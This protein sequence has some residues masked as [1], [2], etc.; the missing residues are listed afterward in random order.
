MSTRQAADHFDVIV[1]GAGPAG[2]A[3][4]LTAARAG[5]KVLLIERGEYPGA[6]NVSG[7]VFY[8]S[9]MLHKVIPNWWEQAP[10]ERFVC[11]RDVILMSPTTAVSLDFRTSAKDYAQPPYNAFTVLRPKFDRWFAGQAEAAGAFL[12]TSTVVDDVIVERGRVVGVRVRREAGE[13]RGDVVIACDG[14]NSLLARRA[15]LQRELHAHELSLGVKEVLGM[16]EALI[17]ERFN[18]SGNE[19]MAL[20]YVGAITEKA[21]GGAFLY[22]NRSSLSL[23]VIAQVS[24]LVETK[25]RPYEL[26]ELFKAHPAVA[27]L[28]RGAKLR[29]YS[30][31]LIPEAGWE[32]M[33]KLVASGMLVA[34]DAAGF[35]LATGLYIEGINYAM[36]SGFAAGE[37]AVY[38]CRVRDF[39]RHT[40]ERY[41]ELLWPY[42]VFTDF[43]RYRHAPRFVNGERLQNL[44]PDMVAAGVEQLFRVDGGP[45]QKIM[46]LSTRTM[47]RFRIKPHHLMQ[48]LYQVARAYLW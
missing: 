36:Q 22:T 6:K 13:I 10:V 19:G 3:A 35:C 16:D 21:R 4:A 45:K 23:G 30:A 12:L 43:R 28:L 14:A 8:G 5:L 40:L 46:P 25:A 29:E 32:M 38:A 41:T 2:S 47:R 11:R 44:Y 18:L 37:A 7:A 39:S 1:V 9:A 31:H 20:E 17:R 34:G 48:D 24:S 15:G 27:P 42:N 33:P 26:L